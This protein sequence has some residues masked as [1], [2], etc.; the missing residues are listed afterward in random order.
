MPAKHISRNLS[1]GLFVIAGSAFLIVLLYWIGKNRHIFGSNYVLRTQ[2]G[3]AEGLKPGN[4]VRYSGLDVGTVGG[5]RFINDTLVEIEMVI[6]SDMKSIIRGNAKVSI[7]SE[8]L[9]GNKVVN[10]TPSPETAP[11]ARE[12]E[13]LGSQRGVSTESMLETLSRTNDEAYLTVRQLRS[14]TAKLD[15]SPAINW[16]SQDTSL[17]WNIR[18]SARIVHLTLQR[19]NQTSEVLHHTVRRLEQGEGTLGKLLTDTLAYYELILFLAHL[20]SLTQQL[21]GAAAETQND[22]KQLNQQLTTGSGLLPA[23]L[24]DTLMR[25]NLQETLNHLNTGSA[26]AN[27]VL[28]G[29]SHSFLLRRYFRKKQQQP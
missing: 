2:T 19:M 15:Q 26:K 24:S 8:G 6:D 10:I 4:N 14:L 21:R 20:D 13:L 11:P 1:L 27:D 28:E 22:L 23:L 9:V 3:N 18:Q 7:G 16:L 5:I 17:Q 12:H 25:N 29:L